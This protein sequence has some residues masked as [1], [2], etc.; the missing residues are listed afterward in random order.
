MG[1]IEV[2]AVDNQKALKQ[3][4]ELPYTLYRGDP[5]W[6][7]PL[8]IA[9]KE[10]LDRHKHPFYP[11]P[12]PS[13]S[14]RCGTAAWWDAWRPFSIRHTT[15]SMRRT[16]GSSGSSNAWTIVAVAD[17]LLARAR[18]WVFDRG[19]KMMRGPMN[20]S[21]NYECGMLVEGFDSTPWS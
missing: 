4:V 11:M 15:A 10:L 20:P 3:F 19:A 1:G 2:V 14:W 12:R 7:P 21:T 13:F 16:P 17:A 9:V 18:Q 6:V 8:R 5:Y